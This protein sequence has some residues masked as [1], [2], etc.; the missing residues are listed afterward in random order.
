LGLL[1]SKTGV[2]VM[3]LSHIAILMSAATTYAANLS[4]IFNMFLTV[5]FGSLAFSAAISLR[6]IGKN[7]GNEKYHISQSSIIIAFVLAAFFM[8]S[9]YAFHQ[10]S[11]NLAAILNE[12]HHQTSKWDFYDPKTHA[13]FEAKETVALGL[14]YPEIGYIIGAIGTFLAFIWI[15]NAKRKSQ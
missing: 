8:I 3:D 11:I 6:D 9:F 13:A 15:S 7:Y 10:T 5:V 14:R 2:V 4:S 1:I 12:L